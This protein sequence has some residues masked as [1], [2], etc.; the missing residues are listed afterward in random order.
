[1]KEVAMKVAFPEIDDLLEEAKDPIRVA[2]NIVKRGI[3]IPK[4][5]YQVVV[6][7]RLKSDDFGEYVHFVGR[8]MS[9][10]EPEV[11]K[12]SDTTREVLDTICG[13]LES[14]GREVRNGQY[15][16]ESIIGA[17]MDGH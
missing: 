16:D 5:E 13:Y 9:F 15:T 7:A 1:M 2:T 17:S 10:H 6:T 3:E 14:K 8:A 4:L 12:L 11:K